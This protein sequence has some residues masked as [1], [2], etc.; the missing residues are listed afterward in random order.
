M[1]ALYHLFSGSRRAELPGIDAVLA[2]AERQDAAPGRGA[3]CWSAPRSRPATRS[4]SPTARSSARSGASSPGSSAARRLRA[5]RRP[6][7]R[8]RPAPAT[9]CASC[10]TSTAPCLI[11]I[12]EWVAYARQLHDQGDLP[13]G[14][15]D[16]QFTFAQALTESAKAAKNACSSSACRRP[17][18]A[19]R[20]TAGRRCGGRRHAWARGAGPANNVV[21]GSR[22]RG[23][24][25]AR[26]RASRS[27]DGG[28][29]SRST[30]ATQFRDR[31]A[32]ARRSPTCTGRSTRSFR[33]SAA[34]PTTSAGSRWPTRS[35][36]SC[37]TGSTTT[38]PRWRSSSAPAAC[39][40]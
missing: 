27:S 20:P 34:T 15:F 24:R 1:L 21:A 32:V 18:P 23:G 12:D 25:P 17:T 33:P 5:D 14:T 38:G 8:R 3:S 39:C 4:R 22:R 35:T 16:T 40:G 10:S 11:L 13:A 30:E 26:R 36:R 19:V 7:T 31:D 2:E 9:C 37:S 29:S 6:T 28:S